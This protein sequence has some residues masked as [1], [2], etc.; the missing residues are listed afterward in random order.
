[1]SDIMDIV[2]GNIDSENS[3]KHSH[4]SDD[5]LVESKRHDN[6]NK[7]KFSY[8]CKIFGKVEL[9]SGREAKT[10]II[11]DR[12][13]RRMIGGQSIFPILR[14]LLPLNDPD[15]PRYG[16]KQTNVANTYIKALNLNKMSGD[17]QSLLHW[18]DPSKVIGAKTADIISG[19]FGTI[20][21]HVLGDRVQQNSSDA[22]IGEVNMI[23]DD[24]AL[25]VGPDAKAVVIRDK[26]RPRFCASE[27]KWL[28]RVV[29]QDL[30]IGL[31]HELVLSAL[32]PNALSRYNEC[33]NLRTVVEETGAAD[34]DLNGLKPTS[35]FSPMLA[36][37]FSSSSHGQVAAVES[38]ME[39]N[40]FLMDVKLDGERMLVHI[41]GGKV[42][43]YS[44]NGLDHTDV[45]APLAEII[46]M[47]FNI[48]SC[49]LDGEVV[50]WDNEKE[51]F[52]P[53]G[54]NRRV[55]ST[56]KEAKGKVG[57]RI[58]WDAKLAAW[59]QYKVF[60]II[61]VD[62]P[63]SVEIVTAAIEEAKVTV[64]V[65]YC[66]NPISGSVGDISHLPLAVRRRILH[67]ALRKESNRCEVVQCASVTSL[68][69]G[70][71]RTQLED[72]FNIVTLAGEEG[73]VV[74]NLSSKY[75]LGEKSRKIA[76]WIK[77][78]PEYGDQTTDLDFV[79]IGNCQMSFSLHILRSMSFLPLPYFELSGSSNDHI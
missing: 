34:T 20:L 78:K 10:K 36:K 51:S 11:F 39:G 7:I 38:A 56:E 47:S 63:G 40:P 33:T 3:N 16:L 4:K 24:L 21:E 28:M 26:I 17:A 37:G 75:Y 67:K 54:C 42:L 74:K 60:D 18:K 53:F 50:A 15:R 77:M 44:R 58:G 25:A 55:G 69:V 49:I 72:F 41:E 48:S 73:L 12:E 27:Q 64:A 30:K 22:T 76:K 46:K 68:D 13:L 31:G 35:I 66:P 5:P 1:M 62:G 45:Y 79:V 2:L 59:L 29:F 14:L 32:S 43:L 70:T 8:V 19:D 52:L 57:G 23:L 71:R 61:Y 9:A 65:E 6:C